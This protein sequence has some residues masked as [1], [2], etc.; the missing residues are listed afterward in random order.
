MRVSEVSKSF[1][2]RRVLQEVSFEL[3]RGRTLALLGPSGCGKSTLLSI[4]AGFCP[5][6]GGSIHLEGREVPDLR[7]HAA[8][9][10]QEDL[11]LPW[12]SLFSNALLP[13]VASGRPLEEGRKR[14]LEL[15]SL[16]GLRGFEGVLPH[17]ASGGMRRRAALARTLMF[18]RPILLL[19][20]PLSG[21]DLPLRRRLWE[22]LRELFADRELAVVWVTHDPEEALS[23]G[24]EI[25]VMSPPP[26]RLALLGPE[27]GG[28]EGLLGLIARLSG[29]VPGGALEAC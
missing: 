1:G 24:D 7:A 13:W 11:L 10:W 6:D 12:K 27:P 15:F 23:V 22:L 8:L 29:F 16:L 3:E 28:K 25:A 9:M 26:A 21:L 5:R 2:E 17:R 18:D 14:L 4:L 19:D 20:E